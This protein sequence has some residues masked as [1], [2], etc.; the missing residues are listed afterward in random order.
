MLILPDLLVKKVMISYTVS[1]DLFKVAKLI[2]FRVNLEGTL[3]TILSLEL[4]HLI[5]FNVK[6]DDTLRANCKLICQL[7]G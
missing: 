2:A 5:A 7:V 6:M 4:L 3:M 1:N